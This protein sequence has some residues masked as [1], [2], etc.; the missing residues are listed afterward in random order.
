MFFNEEGILDIDGLLA[1]N[2]SFK[3]IMEDGV[4]TPEE[5]HAQSENV[6]RIM[7]HMETTYSDEQL[8]QVKDLLV[9]VGALFAAYNVY[10]IQEINSI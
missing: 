10:S 3:R 5:L 2:V 8:T 9:E 7:R 4:V 1:E 6:V